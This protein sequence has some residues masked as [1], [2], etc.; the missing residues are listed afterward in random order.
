MICGTYNMNLSMFLPTLL[1]LLQSCAMF[2][3]RDQV[4]A[5]SQLEFTS[6]RPDGQIHPCIFAF[7]LN[8]TSKGLL[9]FLLICTK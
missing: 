5:A 7:H 9:S 1:A 2:H 6:M 4:S 8:F 3:S